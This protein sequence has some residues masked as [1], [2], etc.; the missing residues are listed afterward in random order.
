MKN[1]LFILRVCVWIAIFGWIALIVNLSL[2]HRWETATQVFLVG[3]GSTF[4]TFE[5][6]RN[7]KRQKLEKA[8][9]VEQYHTQMLDDAF[10]SH[11]EFA[12]AE[13]EHFD[14][15]IYREL[16]INTRPKRNPEAAVTGIICAWPERYWDGHG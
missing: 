10:R 11:W 7:I 8:E 4:A 14:M 5:T 16:T 3:A 13:A 9:R 2:A 12:M 6:I 15:P 1:S